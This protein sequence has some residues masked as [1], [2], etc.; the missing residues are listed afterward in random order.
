MRLRNSFWSVAL[1]C[2][3]LFLVS[4]HGNQASLNSGGLQ[5]GRI[6]RLWWLMF[7]I[8]LAVYVIVLAWFGTAVYRSRTSA[9]VNDIPPQ[10]NPAADRRSTLV[11]GAAITIT[12]VLLF[13]IL[14]A[15][16]LTGHAIANLNSKNPVTIDVIGHQ[17][18]W[19]V[20]YEA[21][22]ADQTV[23]TANEIH[24]PVGQPVVIKTSS[25]DVIHSFWAPN[26]HGK[27]DLIPGYQ[28]A[29]WIQADRAGTFRGQCAEFCGHQHA[30]MAFFVVAEPVEKFKSWLAQQVS[31][32]P[33]PADPVVKQG[34]QVFLTHTCIMCHTIRGSGAGAKLGP[35][36]THLASRMT[37]AAGTLPNTRGN[38]AGWILDSQSIKPGNKMP[39]NPMKSDDLNALLTYLETLK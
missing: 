25:V 2:G 16:V 36:L 18:W 39:P 7:A 9:A 24:I 3:L 38:L 6:E 31:T 21:T 10:V 1:C 22:Q 5:A 27:R 15:S 11:V 28:N 20:R 33:P 30:H 35:D 17:W 34:Q 19:E 12:V 32:P 13:V 23:I 26:L 4:C 29:L 37:I 14:T 8:I